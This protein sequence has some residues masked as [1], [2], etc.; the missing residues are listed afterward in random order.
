[1]SVNINQIHLPTRQIYLN[2]KYA[3]LTEDRWKRSH[4]WFQFQEHVSVP[5][6]YDLLISLTDAVIPVSWFVINEN[7]C[8]LVVS[9]TNIGS[10]TFTLPNGNYDAT[11]IA[12]LIG[13]TPFTVAGHTIA[14]LCAYQT[15][16]NTFTFTANA[17]FTISQAS[18]IFG[19]SG[20]TLTS[21]LVG[22]SH[23]ISSDICVDLSGTRSV[24]IKSNFI[25][26]SIDS[27]TGGSSGILGKVNIDVAFNELQHYRNDVSYKTVIKE[28]IIRVIE[29]SILDE[30]LNFIDFN[31]V[32][33]S[34]TITVDII[35]NSTMEEYVP[36][37]ADPMLFSGANVGS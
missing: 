30:D 35:G 3:T 34:L 27:K 14:F 25:T 13:T 26:H 10:M 11:T 16:T 21:Q 36:D 29:I 33:W 18:T 2:S 5:K 6:S 24:F 28:K 4:C 17:P 7:N 23:V 1:M 9:F 12:T 15:Q 8:N 22:A 19:L 37:M 31:G 20:A 32:D